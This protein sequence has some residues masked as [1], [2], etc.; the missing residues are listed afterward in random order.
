[1]PKEERIASWK[2]IKKAECPHLGEM[3]SGV[4]SD[5]T[6]CAK[7]DGTEDLRLCLQCGYVACCESHHSHNTGHFQETKHALIRPYRCDYDW[8]WCYKCG[9]FLE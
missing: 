9:A 5:K 6:Q 2:H 3:L 8:L 7:C 4:A 1:M